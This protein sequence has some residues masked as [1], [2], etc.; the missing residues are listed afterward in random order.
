MFKFIAIAVVVLIAA[1]LI[2][3][4]TKPDTFRVQRAASIKAAPERLFA[5]INDFERWGAWSPWEK[6]DPGMKRSLSSPASG[7]GATYAWQG[8]KEVGQGRMEI[9]TSVPSSRVAIKL[10]FVKPFEAHNLVQFTLEPD[11]DATRVTWSMEGKTPYYA[12]IIHVFIDMDSMVGKDFET[13]LANLK[14]AAEEPA[15]HTA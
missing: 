5:L 11:G 7:V 13:G 6:K 9:A 14:A 4:A 1:V 3:A 8:N 15:G 2:L 10:D 12:K